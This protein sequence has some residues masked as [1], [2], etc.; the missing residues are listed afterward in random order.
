MLWKLP[1]SPAPL[2]RIPAPCTCLQPALLKHLSR[3]PAGVA[4]YDRQA[5]RALPEPRSEGAGSQPKQAPLG[6]TSTLFWGVSPAWFRL[7]WTGR[8][9]EAGGA[10]G[11][12]C[13]A[14]GSPPARRS[15]P[16]S[17]AAGPSQAV[18]EESPNL[19]GFGAFLKSDSPRE[20]LLLPHVCPVW[21][22]TLRKSGLFFPFFFFRTL[23]SRILLLG[24]RNEKGRTGGVFLVKKINKSSS[25]ES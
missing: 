1:G 22:K 8:R 15:T 6:R 4:C 13:L 23:A 12:G 25:R 10:V 17:Q 20:G 19:G 21:G 16:P 24:G 3:F 9:T 14:L 7:P 5:R 2:P 11:Q 18:E